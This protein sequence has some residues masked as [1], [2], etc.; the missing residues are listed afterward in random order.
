MGIQK[1]LR[2]KNDNIET[3]LATFTRKLNTYQFKKNTGQKGVYTHSFYNKVQKNRVL[4]EKHAA[5]TN[6]KTT[7][8]SSLKRKGVN[9]SNDELKTKYADLEIDLWVQRLKRADLTNGNK[10]DEKDF[11]IPD[12]IYKSLSKW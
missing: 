11:L 8:K 7:C 2:S 4:F 3:T 10:I 5:T 6:P 1:L 12:D 9:D